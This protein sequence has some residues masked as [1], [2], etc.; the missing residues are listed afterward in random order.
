MGQPQEAKGL[1]VSGCWFE[2]RQ[3]RLLGDESCF[4][5]LPVAPGFW[6]LHQ[7]ILRLLWHCWADPP[8]ATKVSSFVL[9]RQ[10][11][12]LGGQQRARTEK[13]LAAKREGA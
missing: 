7:G 3:V 12:L 6:L 5:P 13:Q 11:A 1:E 9:L 4:L 2:L 10:R 8:L